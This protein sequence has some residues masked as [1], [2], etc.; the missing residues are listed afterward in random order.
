[1]VVISIKYKGRK[2]MNTRIFYKALPLVAVLLLSAACINQD[3]VVDDE[4]QAGQERIIPYTASVG[5]DIIT[6]ATLNNDN[7]YVFETGDKLYVWG[8][9]IYGELTL[10]SGAGDYKGASFS[11]NLHWS[12]TGDTPGEY[13]DLHAVLVGPNSKIFGTLEEFKKRDFEADYTLA[14]PFAS[15]WAEAAQF[16]SYF[17]ANSWFGAGK[18]DF[19]YRQQSSFLS[20][21]ITLEDGTAEGQTVAVSISNGGNVVST[22]SVTTSK[23]GDL[24]KAKFIAGI[25][26]TTLD[27]ASVKLGDRDA[28]SFGGTNSLDPDYFYNVTKTYTRYKITASAEGQS[29]SSENK[30]M[31]YETTLQ[32]ILS[33]L[34]LSTYSNLVQDC[35]KESGTSI[36]VTDLG[37]NPHDFQFTVVGEGDSVFNMTAANPFNPSSSLTVTITITVA[38][39]TPPANQ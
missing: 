32:T 4:S 20:F 34:G 10:T 12:G 37:G 2:V 5:S 27:N 18:F 24:V 16:F 38:K 30:P 9:D 7:Y 13:T 14:S 28:I 35:S 31:G 29:K 39:M 11:G 1:M 15:T 26:N 6:R 25:L 22:A 36:N 23:D 19:Y 8:Q 3:L 21:D 33:S 17:S